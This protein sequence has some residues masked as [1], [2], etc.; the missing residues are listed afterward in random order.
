MLLTERRA[1][2]QKVVIESM[3]RL[4]QLGK[5]CKCFDMDTVIDE[6]EPSI[7]IEDGYDEPHEYIAR[8]RQVAGLFGAA[9]RCDKAIDSIE[10][11]EATAST[12]VHLCWGL[13]L[14]C[15]RENKVTATSKI[16]GKHG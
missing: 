3:T 15:V 8:F 4:V 16:C 7:D 11:C 9:C 5:K 10:F 13:C 6:W 14:S 1:T 12:L 2:A